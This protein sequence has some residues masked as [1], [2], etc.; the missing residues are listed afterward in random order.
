MK[1]TT[2]GFQNRGSVTGSQLLA[3]TGPTLVV[4]I[5]FDPSYHPTNTSPPQAGARVDALVDTGASQCCID[6]T[7]AMQLNLPVVNQV[8]VGG[9]HGRQMMNMHMAQ[10]YVPSLEDLIWGHFI[11]ADLAGAGQQHRAIIGRDYLRRFRMVYD[12]P[13]GNVTLEAP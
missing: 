9:V 1:S 7:L 10:I 3:F 4:D 6:A 2:C 5:G 11:G 12:G 8:P 13:S